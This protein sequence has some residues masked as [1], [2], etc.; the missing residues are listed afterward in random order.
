MHRFIATALTEERKAE[1]R[2]Q[3]SGALEGEQA[4]SVMAVSM[5]VILFN[6]YGKALKKPAQLFQ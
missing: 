2:R 6:H 1:Q 4:W 3:V 5:G